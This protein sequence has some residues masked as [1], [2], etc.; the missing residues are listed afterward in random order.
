MSP[1]NGKEANGKKGASDLT[2]RIERF[3]EHDALLR[4]LEI[5]LGDMLTQINTACRAMGTVVEVFTQSFRYDSAS[6][7]VGV[8]YL[9]IMKQMRRER[10]HLMDQAIRFTVLDPLATR[11]TRH[12]ALHQRIA[13]WKQL[14][15]E[16]EKEER[17]K[18]SDQGSKEARVA[19][20]RDL[21]D[22]LEREL[23]EDLGECLDS[24]C[25]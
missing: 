14:R 13:E 11:L 17:K 18:W 19:G 12:D 15:S 4:Q 8:D 9:A 6:Y 23:G 22:P 24:I 16:L 20:L 25:G 1:R 10:A 3:E 7:K 2:H 5:E 21:L